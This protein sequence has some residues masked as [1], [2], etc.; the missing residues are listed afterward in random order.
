MG[1]PIV[2][3][4]D[5]GWNLHP[6][7]EEKII[8]ETPEGIN[9]QGQV[10]FEADRVP[11]PNGKHHWFVGV[12]FQ[13]DDPATEV[14]PLVLDAGNLVGASSISCFHCQ[15]DYHNPQ[16]PGPECAVKSIA[17]RN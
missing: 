16:D 13:V 7:K 10:R 9:V 4:A 3:F 12:F 17:G 6:L 14:S 11:V 15:R 8:E 5:S 2:E 1:E